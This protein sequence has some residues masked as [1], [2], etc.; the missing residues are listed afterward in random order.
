VGI[1][2]RELAFFM[3]NPCIPDI[4][5]FNYYITSERYL[6]KNLKNYPEHLWGGNHRHKYVDTE[7]VRVKHN[8]GGGL[9]LLLQEAWERFK[10]PIAITEAF[11]SCP[12]E[13]EQVRWLSEVC[14]HV[15]NALSNGVDL[16]AVTF[17]ALFGEFS[18]NK[19]VTS[20]DGEYESGAFDVS[21]KFPRETMTAEFIRSMTATG[22]FDAEWLREHGWWKKEDRYHLHEMCISK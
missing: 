19:L 11:M 21:E 12:E 3:E 22:R 1:S 9:E 4:A 15:S 18:W 6:D 8:G 2:E 20:M 17:W 14:S 5:G 16:R 10:I 7:A 13:E